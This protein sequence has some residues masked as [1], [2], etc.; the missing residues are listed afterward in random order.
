MLF[1]KKNHL[2]MI[3]KKCCMMV[4]LGYIMFFCLTRDAKYPPDYFS[5]AH[6]KDIMLSYFILH[7]LLIEQTITISYNILIVKGFAFKI[8][9]NSIR[10][11]Q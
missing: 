6:F 5:F 7:I 4:F 3:Q 11:N 8:N 1:A 9:Y 10:T 2:L